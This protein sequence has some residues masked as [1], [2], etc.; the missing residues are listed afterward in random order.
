MTK[1]RT[2]MIALVL[3]LTMVF[4]AVLPAA[5]IE[6]DTYGSKVD[7]IIMPIITEDTARRIAF[8]RGETGGLGRSHTAI[9]H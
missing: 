8:E 2:V 6:F 3:A 7:E 1:K 9:G 5:A 4:A